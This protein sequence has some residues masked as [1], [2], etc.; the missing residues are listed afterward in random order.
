MAWQVSL[1][2]AACGETVL[3]CLFSDFAPLLLSGQ[4]SEVGTRTGQAP[5][6]KHHGTGSELPSGATL[7][8]ERPAM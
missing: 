5:G 8:W 6:Q 2:G 1:N 4:E 3:F 7:I